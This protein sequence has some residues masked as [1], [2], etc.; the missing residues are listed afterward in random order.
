LRKKV[1]ELNTQLRNEKQS[2]LSVE[3]EKAN[4]Q[5]LLDNLKED[6]AKTREDLAKSKGNEKTLKA[7]L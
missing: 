6:L 5:K 7:E 3:V 4:I 2:L 1:N